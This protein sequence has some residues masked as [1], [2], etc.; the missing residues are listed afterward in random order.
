MQSARR[1]E[2]NRAMREEKERLRALKNND[3][4]AYAQLVS[5]TKNQRLKDLLAQTDNYLRR[6]GA[7]VALER[8]EDFDAGGK[9]RGRS[10]AAREARAQAKG[11]H[12]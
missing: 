3:E 10:K 12:L 7:M 11:V 8:A 5:Q 2:E 6:L 9:P 4:E 1:R